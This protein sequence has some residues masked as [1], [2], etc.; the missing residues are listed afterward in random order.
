MSKNFQR[1]FLVI[2]L[3]EISRRET[4]LSTPPRRGQ[5]H[6][7][8]ISLRNFRHSFDF[9]KLP[10]SNLFDLPTPQGYGEVKFV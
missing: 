4:V 6:V 8:K 1:K 3:R 5:I 9:L 7:T 2:S 10:R